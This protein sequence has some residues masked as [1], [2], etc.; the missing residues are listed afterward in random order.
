MNAQRD[1]ALYIW[2]A[3]A[4]TSTNPISKALSERYQHW[5]L[6]GT[7]IIPALV[8]GEGIKFEADALVFSIEKNCA[9]EDALPLLEHLSAVVEQALQ[10]VR[11]RHN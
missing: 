3:N 10:T 4:G 5:V 7:E 2:G 1:D 9:V 11:V 8:V 6:V